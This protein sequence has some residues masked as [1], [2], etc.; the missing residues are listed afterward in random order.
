MKKL[1]AFGLEFFSYIRL[2]ASSIAS[3]WYWL[4][5]VLLGFA[6]LFGEYC[7]SH[8]IRDFYAAVSSDDLLIMESRSGWSGF[9]CFLGENLI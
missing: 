5:P 4:A 6:Q 1:Q 3:Q 7:Y 8:G 9:S 2:A